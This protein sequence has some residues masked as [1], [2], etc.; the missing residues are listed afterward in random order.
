M[1]EF[2][3]LKTASILTRERNGDQ[4]KK[5]TNRAIAFA[6]A[7]ILLV[8]G[9]QISSSAYEPTEEKNSLVQTERIT[10]EHNVEGARVLGLHSIANKSVYYYK[11]LPISYEGK[12]GTA[13]ALLIGEEYYVS[14][15]TVSDLVGTAY[16]YNSSTRTATVTANG[17][18]MTATAGNYTAYAN[19]RPLFNRSPIV[20]MNDGRLY[21]PLSTVTKAMGIR[22]DI[23][24]GVS[25]SGTLNPLRHA[26]SFYRDDEVLWLARIIEAESGGESLLGQI[27]VGNVVLNRV[28]SKD[29]P[30]TIWGVIFD[31]KYGV[32]FSPVSNGT[33]YN[34]PSYNATLA[35]KI[36]LEGFSLSEDILFFL[37]PRISTSSWIPR[38]RE[39]VFTIMHHDFYA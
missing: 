23:G 17:L 4:L 7:A 16:S 30:N 27:A 31:K 20:V 8:G 33:I 37:E 5:R 18:K 28:K 15:R 10:Q 21:L 22:A 3:W 2:L 24:S 1:I 35:A 9:T 13:S 26:S 12:K 36:C 32:Q 19:D 38:T 29:F 11:R 14:L 6:L 34:T 39:Y 25:L